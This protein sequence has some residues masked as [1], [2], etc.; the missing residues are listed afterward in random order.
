MAFHDIPRYSTTFHDVLWYSTIFHDIPW[1]SMIVQLRITSWNRRFHDQI[2][3]TSGSHRF[4]DQILITSGN[5]RLRPTQDGKPHYLKWAS[6]VSIQNSKIQAVSKVVFRHTSGIPLV[7][8]WS[9]SGPGA[10]SAPAIREA[11]LFFYVKQIFKRHS[12]TD[13]G[14][15]LVNFDF[16]IL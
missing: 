6:P 7:R 3:I 15:D 14:T 16:L 8:L 2:Q 1:Y 11:L 4:C 13:E 9:V 12:Q 5:R 10:G